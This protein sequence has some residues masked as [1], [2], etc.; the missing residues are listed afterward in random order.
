MPIN[1]DFLLFGILPYVVLV[2][3]QILEIQRYAG[4]PFSFSSLSSQFLENRYHFWGS[5]PFH[6]GILAVLALHLVCFLIPQ[7]V[8]IWNRHPARLYALEITGFALGVLALIGLVNIVV[9]RLATPRLRV[10]TSPMDVVLFAVLLLQLLTGLYA[11]LF[12]RWGS[13]WFASLMTPYLWSLITLNPDVSYVSAQ[14]WSFKLHVLN[15]WL[16][17]A[18]IPYTRLV[19]FLVVPLPYLIRRPQVVRWNGIPRTIGRVLRNR[20]R[21]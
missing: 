13:S 10:V 1:A 11:A 15:A 12:N 7:E 16:L 19:H 5:V 17:I 4:K 2:L 20:I 6:Y 9:R 8:L 3:R 14:P 21:L 18:L